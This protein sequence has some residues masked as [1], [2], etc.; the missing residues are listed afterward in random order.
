M[1]AQVTV[2][3]TPL[4]KTTKTMFEKESLSVNPSYAPFMKDNQKALQN[5]Q[6]A[7][8]YQPNEE[9][10]S[11][12][13]PPNEEYVDPLNQNYNPSNEQNPASSS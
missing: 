13:M 2:K 5:V 11:L 6:N 1:L 10:S 8:N 12:P 9:P 4:I 3:T 7:F